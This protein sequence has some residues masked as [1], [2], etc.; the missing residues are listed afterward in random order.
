[1]KYDVVAYREFLSKFS[2]ILMKNNDW[3]QKS[4]VLFRKEYLQPSSVTIFALDY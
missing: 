3:V 1:M 4:K 2:I